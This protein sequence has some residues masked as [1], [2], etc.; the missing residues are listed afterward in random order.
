MENKGEFLDLIGQMEKDLLNTKDEITKKLGD[1]LN[2]VIKDGSD[3]KSGLGFTPTIRNVLAI[4]FA[5]GEAFLRLMDD[6]HS[7]AW[8][9]RN[10]EVRKKSILGT[11]R[12]KG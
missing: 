4:F 8:S 5:N 12:K 7:E 10:S 9:K 6:C 11:A 1:E 2:K 3:G